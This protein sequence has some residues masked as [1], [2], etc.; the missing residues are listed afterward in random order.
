VKV[1]PS[2]AELSRRAALDAYQIFHSSDEESFEEIVRSAA[3]FCKTSVASVNFCNGE[4]VW[5]K[6]RAG[7]D[8]FEVEMKDSFCQRVVLSGES[9]MISD[10]RMDAFLSTNIYVVGEP[11]VR[12]YLG[13]PLK[14][15]DGYVLGTLCIVDTKTRI[16]G[17][18]HL[19]HLEFLARQIMGLLELRKNR[20]ALLAAQK[21]LTAQQQ[22]GADSKKHQREFLAHLSHEL[23]TP[24][25]SILGLSEI[26]A[27]EVTD[28]SKRDLVK[29]L[30]K[31]S[32]NLIETLNTLLE[33]SKMDAGQI[34]LNIQQFDLRSFAE[35]TL[36]PFQT[37]AAKQGL[38]FQLRFDLPAEVLCHGDSVRIRQVLNNLVSNALKFT[39]KGAITIEIECS[40]RKV[41]P[42][43][44]REEGLFSFRIIDSGLGI[45]EADHQQIFE[46]FRQFSSD[47]VQ[48]GSGLGLSICKKIVESM[49]GQI[50]FKSQIDKGSSFWFMLPLKISKGHLRAAPILAEKHEIK[51]ARQFSGTVLLLEDNSLSSALTSNFLEKAGLDV[52]S[53]SNL[54]ESQYLLDSLDFDLVLMDLHLGSLLPKTLIREV[55]EKT[56]APIITISGSELGREKYLEFEI[57]D[58]IQKP[59]NKDDLLQK[60][61]TWL[62][63]ENEADHLIRDWQDSLRKL[64]EQC[65]ADFLNQTI[66]SFVSRHPADV[67]KL[68][69]YEAEREWDK[70]EL[71]AHSMKSTLATLG[72][73]HLARLAG[74]LEELAASKD[75]LLI[76]RVLEQFRI[77]SRKCYQRLIAYVKNEFFSCE[78]AS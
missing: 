54:Q 16:F 64:E 58:A 59:Y 76:G 36:A 52:R 66:H 41:L 15:P 28:V 50:G 18:K 62:V 26:L 78:K 37:L 35:E 56:S 24:L 25:N 53:A 30:T 49:D 72:L 38:D 48:G 5:S 43:A 23:R 71:T 70:L 12:S 65:G 22:I 14:S 73:M 55:R 61:S 31:S 74:E 69:R 75:D 13:V 63:D 9:L 6:A 8:Q 42:Q 40:D 21:E 27:S 7:T 68:L 60:V 33:H 3:D 51:E 20:S 47:I 34:K 17:S 39:S 11:H 46:P 10:A 67:Q 44:D 57:D 1:R 77:D 19:K 29:N 45:R 4:V 32:L 2:L